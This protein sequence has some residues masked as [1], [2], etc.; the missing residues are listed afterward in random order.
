[1]VLIA[2]S[3]VSLVVHP[4]LPV[5]SVKEFIQLAKRRPGQMMYSSPGNGGPQHLAMELFKLESGI[6]MVHVPYKGSSGAITDLVGGHVQSMVLSLQTAAP[7]VRSGRLRMIALMSAERSPAFPDVPTLKELGLA[8]LEVETWY[9]VFAPAATPAP[10]VGKVNGDINALLNQPDIRE[11]LANQ[12]MTAAGGS[13]ERFG[14]LVKSELA[15]WTRVVNA[16][17]I[18]AD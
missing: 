14:E 6:D 4:Q 3:A 5:K 11:L 2:T 12:G 10:V 1:V 16:A 9:G 8:K 17:K 7:F 18:K 13:P 15:R